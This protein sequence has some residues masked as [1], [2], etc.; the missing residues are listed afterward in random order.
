MQAII[1]APDIEKVE[2]EGGLDDAVTKMIKDAGLY[3]VPTVFGLN[4]YKLGR[5]CLKKVPISVIGILNYQGSDVRNMIISII[6]LIFI[7][8]RIITNQC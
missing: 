6:I 4:R 7:I 2:T 5:M 8:L 3:N 1:F